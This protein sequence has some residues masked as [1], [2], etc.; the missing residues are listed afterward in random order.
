MLMLLA[1]ATIAAWLRGGP[2]L[3]TPG[4]RPGCTIRPATVES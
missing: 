3:R 1:L 2:P 4:K